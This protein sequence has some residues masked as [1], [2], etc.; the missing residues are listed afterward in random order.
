[1]DDDRPTSMWE[2]ENEGREA[3]ERYQAQR[4]E[5]LR[6]ARRAARAV[7]VVWNDVTDDEVDRQLIVLGYRLQRRALSL[8]RELRDLL[9]DVERMRKDGVALDAIGD[10]DLAE[11]QSARDWLFQEEVRELA[12]RK[13]MVVDPPHSAAGGS[14]AVPEGPRLRLVRP[15]EGGVA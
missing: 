9:R 6:H 1:M 7:G 3:Y 4:L 15:D 10:V 11:F 12:G 8:A 13:V 5:V 2:V 14:L